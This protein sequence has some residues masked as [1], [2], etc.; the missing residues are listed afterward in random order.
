MGFQNTPLPEM[1]FL[2]SD[3]LDWGNQGPPPLDY[4]RSPY[5]TVPLPSMAS[6]RMEINPMLEYTPAPLI[7]YILTQAPASAALDTR[8]RIAM[9]CSFD[10]PATSPATTSL[11]IRTSFS[12]APVVVERFG[13]AITVRDVLTKVYEHL[14]AC[15]YEQM[16]PR[17]TAGLLDP[18][19][20]HDIGSEAY[21][22]QGMVRLLGNKLRWAGLSPSTTERDVWI[23]HVR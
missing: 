3:S 18:Y 20:Q 23:L 5:A 7:Y 22:Q 14:Q 12:T 16:H 15:A 19:R 2:P 13:A 4:A 11:I 21:V 9:A 10:Q 17:P 8:R 1:P 6:G